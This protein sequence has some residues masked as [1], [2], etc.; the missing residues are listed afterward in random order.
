MIALLISRG[1]PKRV[2]GVR[3]IFYLKLSQAQ[4]PNN[5]YLFEKKKTV[6]KK[7][8]VFGKKIYT[9]ER[10][11]KT[12]KNIIK[13]LISLSMLCENFKRFEKNA[14]KMF[15]EPQLQIFRE[16]FQIYLHSIYKKKQIDYK[17]I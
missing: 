4:T 8:F 11:K 9:S 1:P 5:L 12:K 14:F 16:H 6:S 3:K 7:N 2:F 10:L 17:Y 13:N 15:S